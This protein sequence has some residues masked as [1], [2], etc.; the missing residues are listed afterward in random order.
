MQNTISFLD[1]ALLFAVALSSTG[2]NRGVV[3]RIV[4]IM[5]HLHLTMSK[6]VRNE[7]AYNKKLN[8]MKRKHMNRHSGSRRPLEIA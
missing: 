6:E 2:F 3:L 1:F 7:G 8:R 5:L 4:A